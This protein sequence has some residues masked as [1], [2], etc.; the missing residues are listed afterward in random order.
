MQVLEKFLIDHANSHSIEGFSTHLPPGRPSKRC[1]TLFC[2]AVAWP[3]EAL[4]YAKS[5]CF[6]LV[7]RSELSNYRGE[8][9][10]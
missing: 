5:S 1:S 10:S 7:A 3:T 2:Y 4:L 9:M 8:A 6:L